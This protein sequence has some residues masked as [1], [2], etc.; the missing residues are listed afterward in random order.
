[1]ASFSHSR[2]TVIAAPATTIHALIAD[3][4]EWPK[5]SPWEDRDPALQRTYDGEGVGATYHWKGNS[6]A[7]EGTMTFTAI[8]ASQ[9]DVGLVFV[10]PF[11]ASNE[12]SF[13]LVPVEGGTRVT[14]T[15]GGDRNPLF[16]LM[17]RLFLDNAIGK[18]FDKGLARLKAVAERTDTA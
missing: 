8:S 17:G 14:W 2:E 11:R 9:I 5:W 18:D 10:K 6:K 4:H 12:V 16:A 13:E 15:M 7:G 3:F 1:M